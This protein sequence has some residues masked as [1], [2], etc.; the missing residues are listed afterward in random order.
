MRSKKVEAGFNPYCEWGRCGLEWTKNESRDKKSVK[1][2]IM[3][4]EVNSSEQE[5]EERAS[6]YRPER[7]NGK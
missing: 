6:F 1:A 7:E 3:S 2:N 5:S 4:P